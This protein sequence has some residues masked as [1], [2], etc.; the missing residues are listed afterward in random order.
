MIGPGRWG[1]S[2]ALLGVPVKWA[3]ISEARVI[4]EACLPNYR[5]DP[6]QGT[7]FFQ[8]LTSF[9]VGYMAV[10]VRDGL[11]DASYLDSQPACFENQYLRHVQFNQPLEVYIDGRKNKGAIYKPATS[12]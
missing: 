11:Y 10:D 5:I 8:N 1:S 2:D 6:S 4:V 9:R 7:H 3:Q 12:G